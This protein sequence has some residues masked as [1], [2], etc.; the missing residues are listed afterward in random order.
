MF[1]KGYKKLAVVGILPVL[2]MFVSVSR[3]DD[4]NSL[5]FIGGKVDDGESIEN[6]LIR[7]TLEETGLHV[8]IDTNYDT[9]PYSKIDGD[10]KVYCYV[11]KLK[12]IEHSQV[13]ETETGLVRI[14]SKQD[15]IEKTKYTSYN[16]TAF[17]YFGF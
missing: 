11:L 14:V 6:A 8:E 4:P 16:E 12:D 5:G 15:L 13:S 3:K 2:G 17:K 10:Y 1:I 7:E 9:I